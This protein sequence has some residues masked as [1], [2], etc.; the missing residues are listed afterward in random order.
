MWWTK[1]RPGAM[2]AIQPNNE[3][4]RHEWKRMIQAYTG[5]ERILV[6]YYGL[7]S[8]SLMTFK[9]FIVYSGVVQAYL[10][11]CREFADWIESDES[12][13]FDPIRI[14]RRLLP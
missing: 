1:D 14:V 4:W 5:F 10:E 8:T 9:E 13:Q 3:H 7:S 11:E 2:E 12:D 6:K